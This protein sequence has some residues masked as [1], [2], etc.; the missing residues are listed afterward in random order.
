[1]KTYCG[2]NKL[3]KGLLN[4]THIV[5]NP[6]TCL[7]KGFGVGY[8]M[9][10]DDNY[11]ELWEPIKVND[12]IFCG[13]KSKNGIRTGTNL[14]CFRKGMEVGKNK[15]VNELFD[16]ERKAKTKIL[17]LTLKKL[18]QICRDRGLRGYSRLNKKELLVFV[19]DH[20]RINN[21]N[22]NRYQ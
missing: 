15:K 13:K 17:S 16:E 20:W 1:M 7:K 10:I 18:K 14:E 21:F 8:N 2:N 9:P 19:Y 5:G 22:L 12:K 3:F 6:H 11:R 4:K